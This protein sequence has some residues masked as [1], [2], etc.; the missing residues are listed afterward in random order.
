MSRGKPSIEQLNIS[1][2]ILSVL[3]KDSNL[4]CKDGV[5]C[6]NYGQID[7]IIEAK[8]FLSTFMENK[9]ENIIIYGNS[10]L[11]INYLIVM[12][13]FVFGVMGNTPWRKLDKIKF[14]CPVRI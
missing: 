12:Q 2:D 3:N 9:T 13:G 11:Q 5:D 14:L 1:I 7:G 10:S 4:I 6:R 8:E